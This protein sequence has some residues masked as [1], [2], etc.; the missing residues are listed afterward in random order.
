MGASE[1]EAE[2][3]AAVREFNRFYT[4]RFGLLQK[5][6]LDGEFSL[7]EARI[8]FE[9]GSEPKLTA[10]AL[11]ATLGLD[12]GYISR[13]ITL[14]IKR[15]LV[16]QTTSRTDAREKL[17]TLDALGKQALK[18][19]N[20]QSAL[21]VQQLLASHD[22][23][24]RQNLVSCLRSVKSIL[25][26]SATPAAS[27]LQLREFTDDARELLHEYYEA[28]GVVQ[29]D[30]PQS[31]QK[32]FSNRYSG[33]WVAYLNNEP[34]GC[35]M[36]RNIPSIRL[37]GE[38]KRLYVKPSARGQRI[39]Q[40]LLDAQEEFA[41]QQGLRWIYLDSTDELQT[42]IALYGKRGYVPCKRYN[43]N[44]QATIF[45]RKKIKDSR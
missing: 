41:R 9:I 15:K 42:A 20:Q 24:D 21:Q 11:R 13:I 5:R 32:I 6:H 27:V 12:A 26:R 14:L 7:T 18:R 43:D 22:A 29:R 2:Q 28:V 4:Q 45:L 38:C 23:A 33:W 34:V 35:V 19:L 40:Q 44:P 3:I 36:L 8:L 37:A 39:A 30:T 17:L 16:R 10:S 25:S 31:I 1:V